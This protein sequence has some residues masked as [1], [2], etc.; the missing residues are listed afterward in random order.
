MLPPVDPISTKIAEIIFKTVWEGGGRV[1]K[2]LSGE[3]KDS[4]KQL[5]FNASK[6][7]VENYND[8]HGLLKVLGMSQPVKL[9]SVYT[10]V[11]FLGAE[12]I[13]QYRSES[14]LKKSIGKRRNGDFRRVREGRWAD[15]GDRQQ[16]LMVLG[17]PGAGKST[18]L[19]RMGLAALR[20]RQDGYQPECVPVFVELKRFTTSEIDLEATI[21]TELETC[22]F[23]QPRNRPS[24]C[25]R[26]ASC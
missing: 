2:Q 24:N 10:A 17:Q 22:G 19:R 18:F 14:S 26:K 3:I 1:A 25:W 13:R 12:G 6:R 7:Y 11:R 21:A 16:F 5:I 8:R 20:R 23:P 4:G 9:E 15:G